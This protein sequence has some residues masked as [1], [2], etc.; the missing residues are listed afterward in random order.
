MN[1]FIDN[2]DQFKEKD[3]TKKKTF[4]KNIWYDWLINYIPEPIKTVGG[5]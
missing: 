3:I 5:V 4:A 2:M 1:I